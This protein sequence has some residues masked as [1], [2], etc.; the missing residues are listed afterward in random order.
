MSTTKKTYTLTEAAK[1]VRRNKSTVS[2]V[3]GELQVGTRAGRT[4]LLSEAELRAVAAACA[5]RKCGNPN[6]SVGN[7]YRDLQTERS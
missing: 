7:F 6:F 5:L 4:V 3:A 2:R 1:L